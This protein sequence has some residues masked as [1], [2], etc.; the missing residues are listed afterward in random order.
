M[1]P[2]V[3][4]IYDLK[5]PHAAN[6][7]LVVDSPHSGSILPEDFNFICALHDIRQSEDSY[8]DRF[9]ASAPKR[10]VTVLRSL[11]SR[12]YI[13]LNRA[14]GDLHPDICAE[15][16]PWPIHKSKRVAYGM[17][18]IRHLVRPKEKMYASP[19]TLAE[20]ESRI[21]HYYDPYYVALERELRAAHDAHGRVLHLNLHAMPAVGADGVPLPDVIL[22]DHDGHSCGRAWREAVKACF[23][24]HGLK[25]VVNHPYKG[26]ELTRRFAKPRQ[27]F[28]SLQ[29]EINKSLYMDE[30]TLALHDGFAELEKIFNTLWM[31][32]SQMLTVDSKDVLP[33]A[34]E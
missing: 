30:H 24:R 18:L 4:K 31:E 19:L 1:H 17:G 29:I 14:I 32:L 25:V 21:K 2:G 16:I 8:I 5:K 3:P 23:E 22:G 33:K 11:V 28:H 27:G 26:V 20:I 6:V 9:A 34:A 12:A 15:E 7:P 13:D 10:G